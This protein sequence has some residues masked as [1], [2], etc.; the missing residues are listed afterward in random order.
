MSLLKKRPTRMESV[1]AL[2]SQFSIFTCAVHS[3]CSQCQSHIDYSEKGLAA[4]SKHHTRVEVCSQKCCH[5][6]L[7]WNEIHFLCVNAKSEAFGVRFEINQIH[8][9]SRPIFRISSVNNDE[10]LAIFDSHFTFKSLFG[11]TQSSTER[12]SRKR[13]W[14][15]EGKKRQQNKNK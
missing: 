2:D 13:L 10:I 15:L 7:K 3:H 8:S 9:H 12:R 14:G 5:L 6:E 1:T 4:E 11:F